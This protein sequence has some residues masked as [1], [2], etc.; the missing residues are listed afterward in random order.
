VTSSLSVFTAISFIT[1]ITTVTPQI[2]LPLVGDLAPPSRRATAL[3]VVV[4]G[5]IMG[6]LV[7]RL[8]SGTLTNFVTWRAIYWLAF[9]LQYLIFVLMWLFMPDYPRT[10]TGIN[11]FKL[12]WS[13]VT[14]L[15]KHPVL[16][17]S[18]LV[19]I[20]TAATFTSFWTTLT[21][22]LAGD[23]YNYS[24]VIIGLFALIGFVP[25]FFSPLFAR[26]IT[27]KFVPVFSVIL[28]EVIALVGIIIGTYT[29][30]FTLAGPI[31]QAMCNDAGLQISQ[32]AN[33][34][35]IYAV[36]PKG[37]NR[38][39]TAFMVAT[40]IGQLIGT[41]AGNHVYARGGWIASGSMSVGFIAMALLLCAARGPHEQGWYGWTGGWSI[42]QVKDE[43]GPTLGRG[44]VKDE[45][46]AVATGRIEAPDHKAQEKALEELAAEERSGKTVLEAAAG[47]SDDL[48]EDV[49][50]VSVQR[51]S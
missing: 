50:E 15:G 24:P 9:G 25:F 11:Y 7:A 32:V 16:V 45:E 51:K 6:I 13:I 8:L 31:I 49:A 21:F 14:M 17:Q 27:D 38:V 18:C 39:N 37:R 44:A 34:S 47:K 23:P 1:A 12:L 30:T 3:S 22:L 42:V 26:L 28:G 5:F 20:F 36:E 4:A 41:S 33:R 29:G 19:A 10:N 43:S 48:Q 40:F 2:M 35:A 46:A